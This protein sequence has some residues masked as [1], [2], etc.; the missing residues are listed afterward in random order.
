MGIN[1]NTLLTILQDFNALSLTPKTF[2]QKYGS[3]PERERFEIE[4]MFPG[5]YTLIYSYRIN[6]CLN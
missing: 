4:K 1:L 2:E 6:L 3:C 5:N